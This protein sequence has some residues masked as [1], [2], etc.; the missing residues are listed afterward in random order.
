MG[1][2]Q[3]EIENLIKN[4]E[5][6]DNKIDRMD[7]QAKGACCPDCYWGNSRSELLR[8]QTNRVGGLNSCLRSIKF[9]FLN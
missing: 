5:E 6:T 8:K 4:I 9:M 7:E 1:S 3:R 2:R